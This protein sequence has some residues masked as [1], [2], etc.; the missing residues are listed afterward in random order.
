MGRNYAGSWCS[1]CNGNYCPCNCGCGSCSCSC[2][3]KTVL[4]QSKSSC[5]NNSS[6]TRFC[7]EPVIYV[8]GNFVVPAA[9]IE[10][11]VSVSNSSRLYVGQG[12]QIGD[13]Y[14]QVTEIVDSTT[15]NLKHNGT[16]TPNTT[17]TAVS[18]TYACYSYPIYYVGIVELEYDVD[19]DEITG[20]DAAYAP[21]ADS[22]V[23]PV[24]S[25]SYGYLGPDKVHVDIELTAEIANTPEFISIPL[26]AATSQPKAAFSAYIM[27]SDVPTALVAFKDGTNLIVGYGG[28]TNFTDGTDRTI[29]VSGEYSI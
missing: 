11:E 14:F 7:K 28:G 24:V 1:Y 6:G 8:T 2:G 10:V 9:N 29:I 3:R 23:D 20:I 21:V 12:I 15:V 25:Y 18:P 16:A 4:Q 26:P 17:I 5:C 27:I 19:T 13:G 22:V